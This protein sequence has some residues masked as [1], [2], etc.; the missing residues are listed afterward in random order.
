VHALLRYFGSGG[1]GLLEWGLECVGAYAACILAF[2]PRSG[3]SAIP[4]N[5]TTMLSERQF[6]RADPPFSVRPY[7]RRI[8][9]GTY[10][11]GIG[12]NE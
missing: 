9:L 7:R 5:N 2:N 4:V 6:A 3:L 12:V 11:K 1:R 8:R 10:V